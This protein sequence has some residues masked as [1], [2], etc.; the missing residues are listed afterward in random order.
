MCMCKRLLKPP[1][2]FLLQMLVDEPA[3]F[4]QA[5]RTGPTTSSHHQ[6]GEVPTGMMTTPFGFHNVYC[7]QDLLGKLVLVVVVRITTTTWFFPDTLLSIPGFA[8]IGIEDHTW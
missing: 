8:T 3:N 2:V 1:L 7:R 6:M 5:G 4:G